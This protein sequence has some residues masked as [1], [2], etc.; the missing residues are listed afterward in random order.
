MQ[1]ILT[2]ILLL[3]F[4][5]FFTVDVFPQLSSLLPKE[6]AEEKEEIKTDSAQIFLLRD[7][8]EQSRLNEANIKME[9]EQLRFSM[10]AQD[11][12]KREEQRQR[13]DSLRASTPGVPVVVEEDTLFHFYARRGGYSAQQRALMAQEIISELGSRFNL[14]PD[15]VYIDPSDGV[16]DIMYETTVI[17]SLTE[18]DAIWAGEPQDSL[19]NHTRLINIK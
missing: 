7:S 6:E 3:F 15:S 5:V 16:S 9:L 18:Q 19:A 17:T 4:S 14:Y 8:L 11:S 13:I 12:L 1:K 2:S 10:L